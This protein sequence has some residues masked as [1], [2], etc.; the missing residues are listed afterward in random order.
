MAFC[1]NS[2]EFFI[3]LTNFIKRST[4]YDLKIAKDSIATSFFYTKTGGSFPRISLANLK[5]I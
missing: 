2:N 3:T 4:S 1:N 5:T